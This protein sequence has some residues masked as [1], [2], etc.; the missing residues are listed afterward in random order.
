MFRNLYIYVKI[1]KIMDISFELKNAYNNIY[2]SYFFIK[3][4]FIK[5]IYVKFEYMDKF[6]LITLKTI[7]KT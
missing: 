2:D 6:S 1:Y 7:L 4:T 5:V 3:T